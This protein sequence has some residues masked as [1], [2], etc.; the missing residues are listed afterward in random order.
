MI[1]LEDEVVDL[2]ALLVKLVLTK[3][4]VAVVCTPTLVLNLWWM[5]DALGVHKEVDEVLLTLYFELK[6]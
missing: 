1:V 2:S 3:E 4:E 5:H 6:L